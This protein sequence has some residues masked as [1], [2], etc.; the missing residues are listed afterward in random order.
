MKL[1]ESLQELRAEY[2]AQLNANKAEM[3]NLYDQKYSDLK[4]QLKRT[5]DSLA[6][7]IEEINTLQ[8]K[9]DASS[10]NMTK[11]EQEKADFIKKIKELEKKSDD[12]HAR[13]AKML[14]MRDCEIDV[15]MKEKSNLMSDYQDLM[16]TKVALDNEIATYRKLLETEHVTTFCK[17][18]RH[19]SR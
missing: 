6:A 12:D 7:K 8:L 13:F 19:S 2:E 9:L 1:Q 4:N 18:R 16:D 15:L 14:D 17:T 3:E 10:I 11:F 5:R